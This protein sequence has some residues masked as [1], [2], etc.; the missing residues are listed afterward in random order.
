MMHIFVSDN[1][2]VKVYRMKFEKDFVKSLKIFCKEVGSPKANF[3]YPHTSQKTN[4]LRKFLN[5]FGTTLPVLLESTQHSDRTELYIG[6][7]K[8]GVGKD[9]R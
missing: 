1:G 7:M 9:M 3:V 2:F 8:I 5:K 6:L 4:E